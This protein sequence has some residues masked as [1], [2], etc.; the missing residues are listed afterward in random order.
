MNGISDK[1][2]VRVLPRGADQEPV[3]VGEQPFRLFLIASAALILLFAKPLFDLLRLSFASGLHSHIA[4]IPFISAYLVWIRWRTLP[5]PSRGAGS[6]AWPGF[7]VGAIIVCGTFFLDLERTEALSLRILAFCILFS[8]IVLGCLG[9]PFFRSVLFPLVF[10][11]FLVPLPKVIIQPLELAS[12]FASAEA[13]SWMMDATQSTYFREGYKFMLPGPLTIEVAEECSG[14]RS[15][16]VLFMVGLLAS[17]LFL[18]SPWRRVAFALFVFP[19]GIARNAFRIFT[20][21]TLTVH[22]DRGIIDGPLHHKGGPI[23]FAIS[24]IPFCLVLILFC[25]SERKKRLPE[26]A[27]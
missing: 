13:Y 15:S 26:S 6:L 11:L 10:L 22:W 24:L 16:L 2:I 1:A 8:M 17:Y 20:L 18:S 5:R 21:T 23:F 7:A 25:K 27:R 19:L 9:G 14:I 12:K 4:L 3:S